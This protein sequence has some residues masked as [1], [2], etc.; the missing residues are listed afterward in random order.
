MA[1]GDRVVDA[2]QLC[3]TCG[4]RFDA[5]SRCARDWLL[6]DD[7]VESVAMIRQIGRGTQGDVFEA[8][9]HGCVVAAKVMRARNLSEHDV[10]LYWREVLALS[11]VRHNNVMSLIGA[12]D[13]LGS[14]LIILTDYMASGNLFELMHAQGF[15]PDGKQVMSFALGTARGLRYLHTALGIVHRDLKTLNLLCNDARTQVRIADLG[16]SAPL[17]ADSDDGEQT[18]LGRAKLY[19]TPLWLA[20]EM[21]PPRNYRFAPP[22]DVFALGIVLYEL[23]SC[24]VPYADVAANS[25]AVMAAVAGGAR[26]TMPAYAPESYMRLYERMVSDDPEQRPSLDDVVAALA[27]I[28]DAI[29]GLPSDRASPEYVERRQ[30]LATLSSD[31]ESSASASASSSAALLDSSSSAAPSPARQRSRSTAKLI[32]S[33]GALLSLQSPDDWLWSPP[34]CHIV[35]LVR[36]SLPDV[37]GIDRA[38]ALDGM[39]ASFCTRVALASIDLIE[40]QIEEIAAESASIVKVRDRAGVESRERLERD[41]MAALRGTYTRAHAPDWRQR[42]LNALNQPAGL[43]SPQLRDWLVEHCSFLPQ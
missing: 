21:M 37:L 38:T 29:D 16:L 36:Y 5:H 31:A 33:V 24:R 6:T 11:R 9:Y 1:T 20:P 12:T 15:V 32:A 7:D 2:D 26:P 3:L 18:P 13:A 39:D 34:R 14:R 40:R 22:A 27:E 8:R 28:G 30:S 10:E 41:H 19:G 4:H 17:A 25:D 42:A 43:D 23:L 35:G